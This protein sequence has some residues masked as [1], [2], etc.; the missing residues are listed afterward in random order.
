ME[1]G[2]LIHE[3]AQRTRPRHVSPLV[4]TCTK[5]NKV[6]V[7]QLARRLPAGLPGRFRQAT[8]FLDQAVAPITLI[9]PDYALPAN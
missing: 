3:A 7:S 9:P 2:W 6:N 8:E 1:A 5:G 4:A